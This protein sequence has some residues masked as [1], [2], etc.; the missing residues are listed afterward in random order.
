MM[1]DEFWVMGQESEQFNFEN[2]RVYQDS[3]EFIKELYA[4]T[5]K[6]PK[7][8]TY[9]LISQIRRAAISV[10]SN[11]AEGSAKSKAD[12]KRF[13]D[14][15]RGS[16]FE[17]FAQLRIAKELKYLDAKNYKNFY[18]KTLILSK[19]IMALKNAL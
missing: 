18:Q 7:S 10:V 15:A 19:Q 13:L 8:E 1:G 2:L 16:V 11:I 4:L 9:G 6:F 17:C 12:F 5:L 3:I 14:I